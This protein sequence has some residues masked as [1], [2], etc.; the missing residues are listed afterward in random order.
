MFQ[1][2]S[3]ASSFTLNCDRLV[4]ALSSPAILETTSYWFLKDVARVLQ[5]VN[6]ELT[7]SFSLANLKN[8]WARF[9][10]EAASRSAGM[11]RGFCEALFARFQN[12]I[13]AGAQ[14]LAETIGIF[15]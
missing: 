14:D 15:V 4:R 5:F 12:T 9:L 1:A 10:E 7:T 11:E 6:G 13:N 8:S 2:L 3:C